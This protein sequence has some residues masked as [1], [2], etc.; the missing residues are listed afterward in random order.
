[1]SSGGRWV[2][3]RGRSIESNVGGSIKVIVMHGYGAAAALST[4]GISIRFVY[5]DDDGCVPTPKR[6]DGYAGDRALATLELLGDFRVY[7]PCGHW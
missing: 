5:I 3:S 1:V 6:C 2:C 4:T 7:K